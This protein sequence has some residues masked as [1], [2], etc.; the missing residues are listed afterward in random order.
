M[1]VLL[2]ICRVGLYIKVQDEVSSIDKEEEEKGFGNFL[3]SFVNDP[4]AAIAV[5]TILLSIFAMCFL[6]N[7]FA[8]KLTSNIQ[9]F[10]LAPP[11]PVNFRIQGSMKSLTSGNSN[12]NDSGS[13]DNR[14]G[15]DD[16]INDR[17]DSTGIT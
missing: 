17:T 6:M 11:E 15:S 1:Y 9:D 7:C 2:I 14:T 16:Q 3:A 8:I 13:G 5:T 12:S 10:V 4:Q